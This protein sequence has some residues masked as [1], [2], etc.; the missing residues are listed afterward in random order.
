[1]A[2]WRPASVSAEAG[3]SSGGDAAAC[4]TAIEVPNA[5][6]DEEHARPGS[7]AD[8]ADGTLGK[9]ERKAEGRGELQE[10]KG[11]EEEGGAEVEPG[12]PRPTKAPRR[13]HGRHSDEGGGG[14]R[15]VFV[16]DMDETLIVYKSLLDGK[17]AAKYGKPADAAAELGRR[18]QRL[19][20]GV[21]ERVQAFHELISGLRLT[22][23]LQ[24][25]DH[26]GLC[27]L[28][29]QNGMA[30]TEGERKS[31]RQGQ[32]HARLLQHYRQIE[33]LYT[34]GLAPALS[35]AQL[36]E[37]EAIYKETDEFTDGWLSAGQQ[38]LRACAKATDTP[39]LRQQQHR[40]GNGDEEGVQPN[41]AMDAGVEEEVRPMQAEGENINVLVTSALLVPTVV[42]CL[43]FRLS[44]LLDI[45]NLYSS[46]PAT[47]LA[48]F[49]LI[50]ERFGGHLTRF[51]AIGDGKDEELAASQL[52]WPF[53]KV[54]VARREA[55]RLTNLGI[56]EIIDIL[57]EKS[58]AS[59]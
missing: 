31:Q 59:T 36:E 28:H 29:L 5:L 33:K 30:S 19:I 55:L 4:A 1:M 23:A 8:G 40:M 49:Q 51:C 20:F 12:P 3:P 39:C 18:W 54:A 57:C 58:S 37:W 42:K 50:E 22:A 48:C 52:G 44:N 15:A 25:E 32:C 34:K 11:E 47:K 10:E 13:W 24:M 46:R 17:L 43:L 16:W 14:P 7:G 9:R 38:L 53:V 41:A 35:A 2:A 45:G 26:Q 21:L 6:D 56:G 27:F